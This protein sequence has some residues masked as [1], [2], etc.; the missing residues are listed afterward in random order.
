MEEKKAVAITEIGGNMHFNECVRQN[1]A[2]KMRENNHQKGQQTGIDGGN[3]NSECG[4]EIQ[5][6]KIGRRPLSQP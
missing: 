3:G 5:F 1:G 4:N 6:G 2:G